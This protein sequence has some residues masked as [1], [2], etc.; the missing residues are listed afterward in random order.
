MSD[1]QSVSERCNVNRNDNDTI[2]VRDNLCSYF[3]GAVS[4]Q[5]NAIT[6]N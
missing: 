6:G 3:N 5:I 1:L 4:W 2:A